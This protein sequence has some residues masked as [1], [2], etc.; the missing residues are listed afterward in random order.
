M[1]TDTSGLIKLCGMWKNEDKNGNEYFSGNYTYGTKLLIYTNSFKEKPNDPDYIMY[2]AKQDK[3][4][5]KKA[6]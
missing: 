2:I 4:K 5:D 6:F 1:T 3:P